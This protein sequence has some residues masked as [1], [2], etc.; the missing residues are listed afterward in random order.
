M[1][2]TLRTTLGETLISWDSA[3]VYLTIRIKDGSVGILAMLWGGIPTRLKCHFIE[4]G[5]TDL[6]PSSRIEIA[7]SPH[8]FL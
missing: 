3:K 2:D 7:S 6:G 4:R 5:Y 1:K 8:V